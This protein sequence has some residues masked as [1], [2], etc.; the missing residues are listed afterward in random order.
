MSVVDI[1]RDLIEFSVFR[2]A[3]DFIPICRRVATDGL[4]AKLVWSFES[5][6]FFHAVSRGLILGTG[7][8]LVMDSLIESFEYSRASWLFEIHKELDMRGVFFTFLQ[9]TDCI[10]CLEGSMDP[11]EVVLR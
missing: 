8:F 5:C 4:I 6:I 2:M 7:N 9:L 10:Y 1:C 3:E 11:L